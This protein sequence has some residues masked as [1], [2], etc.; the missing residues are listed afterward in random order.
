LSVGLTTTS[1][2]RAPAAL[3]PGRG[4]GL[5]SSP[6]GYRPRTFAISVFL[7]IGQGA[8][9]AGAS[10]VRPYLPP[11]LAGALARAD[12]GIDFSGSDFSFLES[13]AFLLA[14]F[15]L[16]VVSYGAER[17]LANQSGE[18]GGATRAVA[19]G[20]GLAGMA[21]GALL[22]AGSL[23]AGDETAWP[24]LIGGA[25]C[26]A[27]AWAAVGRLVERARARLEGQA[28][29][30]LSL[31][32]DVAALVLAAIAIF[33]EPVAYAAIAAFVALLIRGGRDGDKKYAGL[34]VLR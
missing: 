2:R 1:S 26:A 27:L 6:A 17:S 7:D 30:L 18:S 4:R 5:S 24:G 12:A 32:A 21:L 15:G 29:G 8:G 13:P 10:G 31:Y 23:A 3:P 25:A 19:L 11:L 16:A 34:R 20:L 9:L 22:F 33:L 28:S 14:V